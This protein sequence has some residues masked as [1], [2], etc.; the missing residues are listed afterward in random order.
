MFVILEAGLGNQLFQIFVLRTL[1]A[2]YTDCCKSW[3]LYFINFLLFFIVKKFFSNNIF[4]SGKNVV[5]FQFS[6]N[7]K[8]TFF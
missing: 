5:K 1:G 8:V 6:L 3:Q 4:I 2:K 7:F